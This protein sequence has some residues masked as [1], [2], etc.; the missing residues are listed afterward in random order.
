MKFPLSTSM[1]IAIIDSGIDERICSKKEHIVGGFS[2]HIG[3][4][5]KIISDNNFYDENGHGTYV[6]KV[7]CDQS[8]EHEFFIIKILN[9]RNL[10]SSKVLYYALK[11]MVSID[12]K[13]IVCCL[14]TNSEE[15]VEQMQVVVDKLNQQGKIVISSFGNLDKVIPSYPAELKGVIGVNGKSF[16]TRITIDRKYSAI[17]FKSQGVYLWGIDSKLK[18]F[19]GNSEAT[20]IFVNKTLKVIENAKDQEDFLEACIELLLQEEKVVSKQDRQNREY[21]SLIEL[22]HMYNGNEL[23]P[24]WENFKSVEDMSDFFMDSCKLLKV[25]YT[26][27]ILMRKSL[28]CLE[29]YYS[30]LKIYQ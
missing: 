16:S 25:E 13:C 14:A 15:Y 23:K 21:N 1:K 28:I 26:S 5:G 30:N 12:V 11:N 8:N 3:H 17:N 29:E 6:Y 22:F 10:A 19:N 9:K 7:I 2:L 27:V 20:A 4:N 24:L 18:F